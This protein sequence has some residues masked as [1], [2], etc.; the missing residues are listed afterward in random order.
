LIAAAP[1]EDTLDLSERL[2]PTVVD[3]E[4][5]IRE[6]GSPFLRALP[7][8]AVNLLKRIMRQDELNAIHGRHWRKVGMDYVDGL[9]EDFGLAIH[10]VGT[11]AIPRDRRHVYVANHPQGGMEAI[12]FLQV[13]HRLQGNVVSPSNMLFEYIP[14]LLPL[15]VGINVFSQ[16]TREQIRAVNEAFASDRQIM[17][18][19]AGEV[20]RRI[21]GRIQDPEWHKT[22]ITKAIQF[23]RD[24]VPCFISGRNSDR[25]YRIAR[26]R[27]LL[28]LRLY[29]ETI[30][31][32][33]E[34]LRH[35]NSEIRFCFGTPIPHSLFDR[36]RTHSQWAQQVR[37]ITYS[38]ASRSSE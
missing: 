38:L 28:G 5:V 27:R 3:L 18:F 15:I 2:T 9:I 14:N 17:I 19:P 22:F 32:P 23:H 34:M 36:S 4:R 8:P 20:S 35:R 26:L 13:I 25:F 24:V 11:E 37:K 7:R 21:G 31:L 29:A 16:N 33:G 30:L 1:K 12:A 10:T 6:S